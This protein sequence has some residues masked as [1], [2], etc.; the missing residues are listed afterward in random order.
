MDQQPVPHDVR[1]ARTVRVLRDAVVICGAGSLG[2]AV[3]AAGMLAL[4]GTDSDL[5]WPLLTMLG[6]GQLIAL[7]GA[8][9]A[10]LGLRTA[11]V[12][13]DATDAARAVHRRLRGLSR[14]VL[15]WS[16]GTAAGWV[17]AN[18]STALL[19]LALAAVTAQ[20][21]VV[22]LLGRAHIAAGGEHEVVFFDAV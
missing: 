18:P 9:V 13:T 7:L 5:A 22:L 11:L 20:L 8:V 15:V 4:S 3:L 19:V 12:A 21:A 2:A 10:A 14:A 17:L 16:V 6:G 1:L